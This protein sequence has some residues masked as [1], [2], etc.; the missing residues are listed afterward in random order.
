MPLNARPQAAAPSAS[1]AK[2]STEWLAS[3][4]CRK[5]RTSFG[6]SKGMLAAVAARAAAKEGL[7]PIRYTKP[8]KPACQPGVEPM[9]RM[10]ST[11]PVSIPE[12]MHAVSIFSMSST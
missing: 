3:S 8:S 12:W 7:T 11:R 2:Q 1:C 5:V 4:F 9:V 10:L 6:G